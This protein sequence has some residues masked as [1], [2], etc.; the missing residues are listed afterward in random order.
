VSGLA[1]RSALTLF[2]GFVDLPFFSSRLEMNPV[3]KQVAGSGV[4]EQVCRTTRPGSLSEIK[5]RIKGGGQEC[6]PHT[7]WLRIKNCNTVH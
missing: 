3:L 1:L 7:S 5:I 6:P 2:S 4:V